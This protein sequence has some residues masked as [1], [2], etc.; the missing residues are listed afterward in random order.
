MEYEWKLKI[1]RSSVCDIVI[2]STYTRVSK[3]HGE[4]CKGRD[5]R[6]FYIDCDSTN[7]SFL[8]EGHKKRRIARAHVGARNKISM[9]GYELFVAELIDMARNDYFQPNPVDPPPRAGV[10]NPSRVSPSPLNSAPKAT[11]PGRGEDE[12]YKSAWRMVPIKKGN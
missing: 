8:V 9:G 5:G 10:L 12:I 3:I 4:L 1:G 7:G 6:Y 2:P 11:P